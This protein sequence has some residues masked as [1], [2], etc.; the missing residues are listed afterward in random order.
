MKRKFTHILTLML[1]LPLVFLGI[2]NTALTAPTDRRKKGA[3][4]IQQFP[5]NGGSTIYEGAAV[6]LNEEGYLIPFTNA[7]N[8]SFQ[9]IA[10][11]T[12]KNTTVEG[13]GSDGQLNCRVY[14]SG[15]F[16]FASSEIL[17][18]DVGIKIYL[19][20]DNT[21]D[22]V[23]VATRGLAGILVELESSTLGWVD[24]DSGVAAG[25]LTT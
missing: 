21:I 12:V 16:R 20:D 25:A 22:P 11:E 4:K 8:R 24:I 13:F 1:I 9:G 18:S 3:G 2:F 19:L 23:D 14:R 7:A 17:Q 15:T 10:Y 6:A 5:V